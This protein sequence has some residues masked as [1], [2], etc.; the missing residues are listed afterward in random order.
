MSFTEIAKPGGRSGF[1]KGNTSTATQTW[2]L[3]AAM[4]GVSPS[5]QSPAQRQRLHQPATITSALQ[6][7]WA[8]VLVPG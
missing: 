5:A 2:L 1:G 3:E 8:A 4:R 7:W 6:R